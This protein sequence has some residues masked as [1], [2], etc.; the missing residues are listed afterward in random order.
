MVGVIRSVYMRDGVLYM[1]NEIYMGRRLIMRL[2][3]L[4]LVCNRGGSRINGGLVGVLIIDMG[5]VLMGICVVGGVV[6]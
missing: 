1:D 5:V 2:I 6:K 4:L 3:V